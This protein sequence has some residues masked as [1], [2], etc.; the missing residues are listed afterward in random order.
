MNNIFLTGEIQVGKTTL[1]NKILEKINLSIGG[2]QVDRTIEQKGSSYIKEFFIISLIN[3]QDSFKIATIKSVNDVCDVKVFTD[4]FETVANTIINESL[5]SRNLIVLD[6]LG[7]MENEATY[8][9]ESVFSVLNSPKLTLGV[10]KKKPG[11]FIDKIRKRNDV[12][13]IEVTKE[14][15]DYLLD[16]ILEIIEKHFPGIIRKNYFSSNTNRIKWYDLALGYKGCEYPQVFLDKIYSYIDNMDNMTILDMG[17]GTGAFTIPLSQKAKSITALDSSINMISHLKNKCENEG[18]KNV[19]YLIS[20]FEDIDIPPHDIIINAFS[21]GVTKDYEVLQK[22][23]DT[24]KKFAFIISHHENDTYKFGEEELSKRL[25]RK[26]TEKRHSTN[27]G[28][29]PMLDKLNLDYDYSEVEFSFPQ[30]FKD[31]DDAMNFFITYFNINEEREI[32]ILQNYLD[33]TLIAKDTGYIH[34]E[35]RL[36]RFIVIKK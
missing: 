27:E 19:N 34:P 11:K 15:R 8:F 28:I 5:N 22:L 9:Q 20:P 24:T 35:D 32:S 14:N 10:I 25:G 3:G 1:L 21:V 4:S 13:L 29:F 16:D 23:C 17:S 33:E 2:F 7:T 6:E 30:Y 18:I 36:S 26:L 31:M 12:M